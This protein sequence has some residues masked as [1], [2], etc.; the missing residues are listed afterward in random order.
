VHHANPVPS[1]FVADPLDEDALDTLKTERSSRQGSELPE[2]PPTLVKVICA[3]DLNEPPAR[4]WLEG[5]EE[6]R[7]FR[8]R[9]GSI[10]EKPHSLAIVLDDRYA[11]VRHVLLRRA[12]DGFLVADEGSTNGTYVEGRKLAAGEER[13]VQAALFEV[14]HTFFHLRAAARGAREAPGDEGMGD[15][16]TWNPE[17]A[18]TLAAAGRL[19][20]RAH[21]LL[22]TGESGVG[23]EVVARWL[24]QV[25]ERQGALV[26]INCAALPEHLLEDE[27]FGHLRGAFSGAHSDR[28]GLIRA[29]HE[30]TLLLDEIG[31][32]PLPLQAK[33]LRVIEDRRVRPVGAEREFPVDVLVIAA[34]NRDLQSMA[35]EG[36]FRHDLLARLGLLRLS[37]PP[38]RAR[39]EDLGLLIRQI[40]REVPE[41][42]TRVRFELE[43]M[44]MLL[45]HD[46]P[47][48][49]REL[50]RVLL[51]AVDLARVEEGE[52]IVVGP[53][54]LPLTV[55][56]APSP[57][58]T[59]VGLLSSDDEQLRTRIVELLSEHRGN[60]AA[61]ARALAKPRT[62]VQRLM[63]RLG[64]QRKDS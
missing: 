31:D 35:A 17:F 44:R 63:A 40:L 23:K 56:E 13:I 55:N 41:G 42:L 18:L 1:K 20:R 15:P 30:G 58:R 52:P 46:W 57:P 27:L 3:D 29:A 54:H 7:I 62:H 5:C 8:G 50:R 9:P 49:V 64:I 25:S 45:L 59:S 6:V 61:V 37:V 24:H 32:M 38:L 47:L 51:A 53:Q 2:L 12:A 43:T 10:R 33:L 11:S 48:N 60:V 39:R 21:D 19:A 16:L 34:T 22:L 36:R 4:H 14:G 26:A 28:P